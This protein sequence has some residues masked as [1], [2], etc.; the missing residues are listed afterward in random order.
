MSEVPRTSSPEATSSE[1]ETNAAQP[2][3]EITIDPT[4]SGPVSRELMGAMAGNSRDGDPESDNRRE[5]PSGSSNESEESSLQSVN[6]AASGEQE[7]VAQQSTTEAE[8]KSQPKQAEQRKK[9]KPAEKPEFISG[10]NELDAMVAQIKKEQQEKEDEK[11]RKQAEREEAERRKQAEAE[12]SA[13]RNEVYGAPLQKPKTEA[14]KEQFLKDAEMARPRMEDAAEYEE[15]LQMTA[16][17]NYV[18]STLTGKQ[19]L[20][21]QQRQSVNGNTLTQDAEN[22]NRDAA[23]VRFEG[24]PLPSGEDAVILERLDKYADRA[25]ELRVKA[26]EAEQ[27]GN[28]EEAAKYMAAYEE[29]DKNFGL[30]QRKLEKTRS[31]R[32][33]TKDK[34]F[35]GGNDTESAESTVEETPRPVAEVQNGG[36]APKSDKFPNGEP[37]EAKSEMSPAE[38]RARDHDWF[39]ANSVPVGAEGSGGSAEASAQQGETGNG[40]GENPRM[41]RAILPN[42]E[43]YLVPVGA[44]PSE[45]T[46]APKGETVSGTGVLH[47]EVAKTPEDKDDDDQGTGASGGGVVKGFFARRRE[48]WRKWRSRDRTKSPEREKEDAEMTGG[49][50]DKLRRITSVGSVAVIIAASAGIYKTA[51]EAPPRAENRSIQEFDDPYKDKP[52][53]SDPEMASEKSYIVSKG[54]GFY[55]LLSKE[56]VPTE[57]Q[58]AALK[59]ILEL[60]GNNSSVR[61]WVYERKPNEPGIAKTG[62]MPR[63][64]VE[65]IKKAAS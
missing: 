5:A 57:K 11:L 56:G 27:A 16:Q 35:S 43:T 6:Y 9:E 59:K 53:I 37:N 49:L 30:L 12:A 14:E 34:D 21:E 3:R 26:Y 55:S 52:D 29:A 58:P 8:A 61:P 62:A 45:E 51:E 50:I 41:I 38:E 7:P 19:G 24:K 64:V 2:N 20:F 32:G 33:D 13:F 36:E 54:E 39:K 40:T 65:L 60:A 31:A 46:A 1:P 18:G 28:S 48:K 25:N 44:K 47:E 4:F 63:S 10:V 23:R 15:H 42:G 17:P 22:G